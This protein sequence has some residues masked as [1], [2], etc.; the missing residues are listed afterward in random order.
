M[1]FG[2]ATADDAHAFLLRAKHLGPHL[3]E[4]DASVWATQLAISD[5]Y[6]AGLNH[7][8]PCVVGG[9]A[10]FPMLVDD[11]RLLEAWFFAAPSAR[12]CMRFLLPRLRTLL[13]NAA[14]YQDCGVVTRIRTSQGARI[15]NALGFAPTEL[16][17]ISQ[18][19]WG[20][21]WPK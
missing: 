13:R 15:A 11:R 12:H 7:H 10:R 21:Q 4:V 16:V 5:L 1:Y 18:P 9:L 3:G 2:P 17:A 20:L 6:C 19:V 14:T 8:Y